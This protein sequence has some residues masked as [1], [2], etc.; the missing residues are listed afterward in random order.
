VPES[1]R[2]QG[3]LLEMIDEPPSA[4]VLWHRRHTARAKWVAVA[5]VESERDGWRLVDRGGDW[6]VLRRGQTP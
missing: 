6:C 1:P 5:D 4:F 3:S 2:E